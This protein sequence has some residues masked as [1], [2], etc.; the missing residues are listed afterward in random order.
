M[1]S[2]KK[3]LRT[4]QSDPRRLPNVLK[5]QHPGTQSELLQHPAPANLLCDLQQERLPPIRP[6]EQQPPQA[7]EEQSD[8]QLGQWREEAGPVEEEVHGHRTPVSREHPGH[9]GTTSRSEILESTF[10]RDNT[11]LYNLEYT[12]VLLKTFNFHFLLISHISKES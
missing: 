10:L 2:Q 7:A 3:R 9:E 1:S 11:L 4:I 5:L 8:H 12:N 6:V